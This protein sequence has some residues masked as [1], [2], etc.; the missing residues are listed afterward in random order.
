ML[1]ALTLILLLLRFYLLTLLALIS[2]VVCFYMYFRG[3]NMSQSD[4]VS[5]IKRGIQL[6]RMV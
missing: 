2:T 5:G 4:I 6:Y 3:E 1:L